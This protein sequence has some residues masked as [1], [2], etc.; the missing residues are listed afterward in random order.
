MPHLTVLGLLPS[1]AVF[2]VSQ[3]AT[4]AGEN[5]LAKADSRDY[6][7]NHETG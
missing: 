4:S 7:E 5:V 2:A 1:A 6:K 3:D